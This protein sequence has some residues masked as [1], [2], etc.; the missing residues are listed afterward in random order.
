MKKIIII[1]TA[2]LYSAAIF[3]IASS[4]WATDYYVD[5]GKSGDDRYSGTQEKPWKTITLKARELTNVQEL[6]KLIMKQ[7]PYKSISL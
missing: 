4:A 5:G 7:I 1:A 6:L 3:G 2:I